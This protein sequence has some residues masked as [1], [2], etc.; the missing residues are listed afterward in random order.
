M[1][2]DMA[3]NTSQAASGKDLYSARL[4]GLRARFKKEHPAVDAL[5]VT[6]D[7]D[8]RYLTGFIGHDSWALVPLSGGSRVTIVSDRRF[9][10]QIQR[11]AP[12]AAVVM[13]TGAITEATA[14]ALD[15][16]KIK[17][18]GVQP[19]YMTLAMFKSLKKAVGAGRVQVSADGL[20]KQRSV[21]DASEVALIKQAGK[22]Q[23]AAYE[24]VIKEI[25]AG[26]DTEAQI[27]AKLEMTMRGM[28]ADGPSFNTI[29]AVG[30][31]ASLPH[32]IPGGTKA[33]KNEIILID[34]GAKLGG[35]CSDMTRVIAL[36]KMPAKMREVYQVVLEAQMAAIEAI[37]PGKVLKDIDA[38][39]RGIIDK[40]GYGKEFS[41]SLGHGL[42]LDIHEQP[43]LSTKSEG[44]LEP[45]QVVTVEPGIYLPGVGG[46][47]IE[48]DVLVT[49]K[50]KEVLTHLPKDLN[51]AII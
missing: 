7:K 24:A 5:L 43:T 33:K 38:V 26:V 50:G 4:S 36:G 39:A 28:G 32:A 2:L 46:V 1:M 9:E 49:A 11:E 10:E 35:Y 29:I 6:N 45:G 51:C 12:Q 13:R 47:R 48:D 16:L 17:K 18:I 14:K 44:V 37:A 21:K 42:G 34:W 3:K 22:I 20:I 27:A 40:A 25:R 31:N 19:D 30:A 8:I 23:Q 15:K 41:H